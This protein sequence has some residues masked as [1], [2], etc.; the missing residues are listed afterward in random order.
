MPYHSSGHSHTKTSVSKELNVARVS[1][2]RS[3]APKSGINTPAF[4]ESHTK[5]LP[6]H[7][8]MAAEGSKA[9]QG[10]GENTSLK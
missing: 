1:G 2:S 10:I 3:P 8:K 6:K 7:G 9:R 4:N 5:S